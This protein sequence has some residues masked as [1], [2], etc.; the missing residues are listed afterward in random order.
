MKFDKIVKSDLDK[1]ISDFT[2]VN[3]QPIR[4]AP[5]SDQGYQVALLKSNIVFNY[6][7]KSDLEKSNS[8]FTFVS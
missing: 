7:V 6:I 1:L 4:L 5:C 3:V 8:D 2:F